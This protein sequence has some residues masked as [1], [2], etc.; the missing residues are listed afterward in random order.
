MNDH[1][2]QYVAHKSLREYVEN[3]IDEQLHDLDPAR[4]RARRS[5]VMARLQPLRMCDGCGRSFYITTPEEVLFNACPQCR[6]RQARRR[7][8]MAA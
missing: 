3:V 5:A 2:S 8:R 4:V 7:R 1:E 6:Q